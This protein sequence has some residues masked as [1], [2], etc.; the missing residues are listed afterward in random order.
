MA[1]TSTDGAAAASAA[2]ADANLAKDSSGVAPATSFSPSGAA[3]QVVPDVDPSHPAVDTDPRASTSA[4]D[5]KIVFND[6]NK[7]GADA[8]ADLLKGQKFD[9]APLP[10]AKKA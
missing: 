5:N 1:T 2:D 3:N 9:V 7:S 6:P 8:V 10:D 4:L